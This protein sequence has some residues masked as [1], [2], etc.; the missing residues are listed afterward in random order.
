MHRFLLAVSAAVMCFSMA[1]G[2]AEQGP[3]PE[4]EEAL[5]AEYG[6]LKWVEEPGRYDL[7]RSNSALSFAAGRSILL[8]YDAERLLFLM[9]G[10]EFP[11]TEAVLYDDA[12]DVF[13]VYEFFDDGF[14]KDEDWS[15]VDA[16]ALLDSVREGSERQ[17]EERAKHGISPMTVTGWRERPKYDAASNMVRWAIEFDEGGSTTVNAI[18][19]KLSRHGYEQLTWVGSGKQYET[20]GGLLVTAM[21]NHAFNEGFRYADFQDGDK[22]AAYGLGALVATVAGAKLGKGI[23][24]ALL[25][26]LK[27]GWILVVVAI[28]AIGGLIKKLRG[29]KT[30][31]AGGE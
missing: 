30:E 2:A 4:T 16:D 12:S 20:M 10:S 5:D 23:L 24:V 15:D 3:Y 6:K 17:N 9:N 28:G 7:E 11:L 27:K 1:A 18:A 19:L 13:V 26:F 22:V 31:P 14:V 25:L 29:G 21:D 8:G